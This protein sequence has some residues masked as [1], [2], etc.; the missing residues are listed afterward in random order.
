MSGMTYFVNRALASFRRSPSNALISIFVLA[1]VFSLFN[2]FLLMVQ[3]VDRLGGNWSKGVRLYVFLDE[4]SHPD[5]P[6][7]LTGELR[8]KEEVEDVVY[9]SQDVARTRFLQD[10]PSEKNIL[11]ELDGNP[12][13]A[14]I[15]ATV[16]P[17]FAE[18][19]FLDAL[20]GDFEKIKGVEEA[21][22]GREIFEKLSSLKKMTAW[23]AALIGLAIALAGLFLVY[24]TIRISIQYRK[25]EIGIL[26]LVGATPDF[27]RKPFVIEGILKGVAGA[28]VSILFLALVFL[29]LVGPVDSL[30]SENF[31]VSGL[32]FLSPVSC[33]F[34]LAV[35]GILGGFGSLIA[36][37]RHES[38]SLT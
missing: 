2:A 5:L 25:D 24:S 12:F 15:E 26:E 9:V 34:L 14:S 32:S 37:I 30:L 38:K 6:Q 8:Q 7:K 22:Y 29:L 17:E 23:G 10:F 20:V 31:G 27:I 28:L 16:K 4:D 36:V 33:L 1:V 11:D 19:E 13:P 35:G 18:R 21:V 3:N